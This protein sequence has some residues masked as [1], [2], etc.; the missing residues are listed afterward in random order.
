MSLH[1]QRLPPRISHLCSVLFTGATMSEGSAGSSDDGFWCCQ[2]PTHVF[3]SPGILA[4]ERDPIFRFSF[5][6]L[7]APEVLLV[8]SDPSWRVVVSVCNP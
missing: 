7:R 4:L 2:D 8:A 6:I 5:L 3:E 1:P